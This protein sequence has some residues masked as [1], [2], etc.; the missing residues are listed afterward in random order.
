[1]TD[2]APKLS[3]EAAYDAMMKGPA[4]LSAIR[5]QAAA[6]GFLAIIDAEIERLNEYCPGGWIEK[7]RAALNSLG[8]GDGTEWE[9]REAVFDECRGFRWAI[10]SFLAA[11]ESHV[12]DRPERDVED[13]A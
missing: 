1:M 10:N 4:N 12:L 9:T 3:T 6:E 11:V 13:A 5:L 7:N 2:H 8:W